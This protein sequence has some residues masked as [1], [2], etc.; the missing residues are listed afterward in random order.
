[1]PDKTTVGKVVHV[2]PKISVAVLEL[3]APLKE[4]DLIE[5][6]GKSQPFQQKVSSMQIE[7]KPVSEAKAG[8]SIGLKLDS[9]A[10]EGDLV[11]KLH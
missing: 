11:H 8:E 9:P 6:G 10:A 7:H 4:G 1:M 5:I 3:T 2:Y